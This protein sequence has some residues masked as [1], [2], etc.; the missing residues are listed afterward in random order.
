MKTRGSRS[1][2]H[3]NICTPVRSW[4]QPRMCYTAQGL[5]MTDVSFLVELSSRPFGEQSFVIVV[6][7]LLIVLRSLPI[8]QVWQRYWIE[9]APVA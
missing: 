7:V 6:L 1:S 9:R 4:L 8:V 5:T 3:R 2:T